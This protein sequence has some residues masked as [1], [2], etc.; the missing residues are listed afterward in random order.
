[1]SRN[2]QKGDEPVRRLST[3][4]D[5]KK[6]QA[7]RTLSIRKGHRQEM[8]LKQRRAVA[9]TE[10]SLFVEQEVHAALPRLG[11]ACTMFTV[12]PYNDG[13][14]F[15]GE[16]NDLKQALIEYKYKVLEVLQS[17]PDVTL[18]PFLQRV[19]VDDITFVTDP[20]Y[21]AI[22]LLPVYT[23]A[24]LMTTDDDVF[25][26]ALA[27]V[28]KLTTKDQDNRKKPVPAIAILQSGV[29]G[30]LIELL[31]QDAIER[32][33]LALHILLN[34]AYY[35]PRHGVNPTEIIVNAGAIDILKQLIPGARASDPAC[36]YL[37]LCLWLMMNIM[38]DC[39]EYK[40]ACLSGDFIREIVE[41]IQQALGYA[42]LIKYTSD[43]S[44][45]SE[46]DILVLEAQCAEKAKHV[47]CIGLT[48]LK[49]VFLFSQP[50]ENLAR[51]IVAFIGETVL[52]NGHR[53][54]GEVVLT[55]LSVVA[56]ATDINEDFVR[57]VFESGIYDYCFI[58]V[59]GSF[60]TK[61]LGVPLLVFNIMANVL[62]YSS[63]DLKTSLVSN[64]NI[65]Q[66]LDTWLVSKE[67]HIIDACLR[68]VDAVSNCA[69][70]ARNIV[71]QVS[72][73]EKLAGILDAGDRDQRRGVVDFLINILNS[74]AHVN[75]DRRPVLLYMIENTPALLSGL[76]KC[77]VLTEENNMLLNALD[78]VMIALDASQLQN[79]RVHNIAIEKLTAYSIDSYLY[80]LRDAVDENVSGKARYLHKTYFRQFDAQ[81]SSSELS[82]PNIAGPTSVQKPVQYFNVQ[83]NYFSSYVPA[84]SSSTNDS[85]TTTESEDHTYPNSWG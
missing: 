82:F 80:D 22:E 60:Q 32:K 33:R 81:D 66:A 18:P 75:S 64:P 6:Q 13:D 25:I 4:S 54:H 79:K 34:L 3:T 47:V 11:P 38:A 48:C 83:D 5:V 15:I 29:V 40:A 57:V 30:K 85:M 59:A 76:V 70:G 50:D 61:V 52:S 26:N 45:L 56:R 53:R 2:T 63:L 10:P 84:N 20:A 27:C 49:C 8:F 16:Y 71:V 44:R 67:K 21:A 19:G 69:A 58:F 39:D 37:E 42:E 7:T 24:L 68:V 65:Y 55:A 51:A 72:V 73:V 36:E 74:T 17:V 35:Q 9:D 28:H 41:C 14:E 12:A 78:F 62:K 31:S 23:D 46:D 43:I 77:L 1:M